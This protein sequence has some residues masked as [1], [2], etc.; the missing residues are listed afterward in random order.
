MLDFRPQRPQV[1][2]YLG[3]G[4]Q[5]RLLVIVLLLGLIVMAMAESARPERWMWLWQV[6]DRPAARLAAVDR[7]A[8]NGV[9]RDGA[10]ATD[11]KPEPIPGLN[12]EA[13]RGLVDDAKVRSDE[14]PIE[15]EALRILGETDPVTIARASIGRVS[16]VELNEQMAAYRGKVVTMTGTARRIAQLPAGVNDEGILSFYEVWMTPGDR[17]SEVICVH[18][19]ELPEGLPQGPKIDEPIEVNGVAFKRMAYQAS[20]RQWISQPLLVARSVRWKPRPAA[21]PP[22]PRHDPTTLIT[23]LLGIAVVVVAILVWSTRRRPRRAMNPYSQAAGSTS[24]MS[25]AKLRELEVSP[26]ARDALDHPAPEQHQPP[27]TTE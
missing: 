13:M 16:F 6:A 5:R 4:E 9:R 15:Y 11:E 3:R 18:C 21:A 22:A 8:G 14:R 12:V 20:D 19:F 2:N 7:Q 26:E 27:K 24:A 17:P 10:A 1:R 25:Y 23:T